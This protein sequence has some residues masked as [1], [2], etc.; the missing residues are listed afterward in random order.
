MEREM[1][2]EIKAL[3]NQTRHPQTK[4][5]RETWIERV[6]KGNEQAERTKQGRE[7]KGSTLRFGKWFSI[8]VQLGPH[9][10]PIFPKNESRSA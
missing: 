5:D 1:D 9:P 7:E 3:H 10:K 4:K 2:S 8:W 6:E